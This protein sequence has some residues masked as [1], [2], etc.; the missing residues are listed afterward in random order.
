M[1]LLLWTVT[2]VDK[3]NLNVVVQNNVVVQHIHVLLIL[4]LLST[5]WH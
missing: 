1:D 3:G 5:E 2:V 4:G